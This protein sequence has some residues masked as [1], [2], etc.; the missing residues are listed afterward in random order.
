MPSD[1]RSTISLTGVTVYES[2]RSQPPHDSDV[3]AAAEHI[4]RDAQ[5]SAAVARALDRA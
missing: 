5:L 1:V 2:F 3:L 4:L